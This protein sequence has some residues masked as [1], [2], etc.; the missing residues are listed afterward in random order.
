MLARPMPCAMKTCW[1]WLK[2]QHVD[3]PNRHVVQVVTLSRVARCDQHGGK[4]FSA[5][6]LCCSDLGLFAVWTAS[7]WHSGMLRAANGLAPRLP[8][9]ELQLPASTWVMADF[10]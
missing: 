7:T 3:S 5:H 6:I 9:V 2:A 8:A 10:D 4:Q 1:S